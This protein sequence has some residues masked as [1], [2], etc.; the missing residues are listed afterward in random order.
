MSKLYSKLA[1]TFSASRQHIE[2]G[3]E[4]LE[5]LNL[6]PSAEVLDLGCGNGRFLRYL[7][8]IGLKD[9]SY[10]GV[11]KSKELL[12]EGKSLAEE[13]GITSASFIYSDINDIDFIEDE[14]YDLVVIYAAIHH[15]HKFNNR[16]NLL[17]SASNKLKRSGYL[18]VSF[19]QFGEFERYKNRIDFSPHLVG[20]ERK[21]ME[22]NDYI[23]DWKRGEEVYRY[24]HWADEEEVEKYS[25]MLDLRLIKKY[26]EDGRE[27]SQ[28]LYCLWKKE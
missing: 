7:S 8:N 20:M 11:D 24:V 6:H 19:W 18:H 13:L 2:P 28:N 15:I 9:L 16:I 1:K 12:S 4:I 23:M 10:T 5:F 27:R 21:E 3:W 17:K 26:R 25:N 14:S 22:E